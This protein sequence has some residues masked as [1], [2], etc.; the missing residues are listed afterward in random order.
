MHVKHKLTFINTIEDI[1]E[2]DKQRQLSIF[3]LYLLPKI[4]DSKNCN[5]HSLLN[6]PGKNEYHIFIYAIMCTCIRMVP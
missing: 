3:C 2:K 1:C 6:A 5:N 4:K